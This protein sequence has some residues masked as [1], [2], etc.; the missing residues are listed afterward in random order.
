M[1]HLSPPGGRGTVEKSKKKQ[2]RNKNEEIFRSK[3]SLAK[4]GVYLFLPDGDVI[5]ETNPMVGVSHARDVFELRADVTR[6]E[7]KNRARVDFV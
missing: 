7:A 2:F 4:R 3:K 6:R 1:A 5:G